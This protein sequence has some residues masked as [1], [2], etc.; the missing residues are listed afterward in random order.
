MS[1]MSVEV[2]TPSASSASRGIRVGGAIRLTSAP[3]IWKPRMPERATREWATSPT[4]AMC[5]PSSGP[6]SRSMV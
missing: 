3:I 6:T 4:K 2:V 1:R 5:R